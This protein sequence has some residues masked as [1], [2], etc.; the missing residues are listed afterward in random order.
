MLK[1]LRKLIARG[2]HVAHKVR[3]AAHAVLE[4]LRRY[5]ARIL[6]V[7]LAVSISVLVSF[8]I[9]VGLYAIIYNSIVPYDHLIQPIYFNYR[10]GFSSFLSF[11]FSLCA[12]CAV[13]FMRCALHALCASCAVRFMRCALHALHAFE[14]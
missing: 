14:C 6:Q 4:F 12:S 7:F 11:L 9:A 5:R 10:S 3:A 13:R 8:W 1:L 2:V